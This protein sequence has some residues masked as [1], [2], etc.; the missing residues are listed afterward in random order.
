MEPGINNKMQYAYWNTIP[1]LC[2]VNRNLEFGAAYFINGYIRTM[3]VY[4]YVQNIV[5]GKI[6]STYT[7]ILLPLSSEL[8][9]PSSVYY[10]HHDFMK[11]SKLNADDNYNPTFLLVFII[12]S[13]WIKIKQN[14][15]KILDILRMRDV[16]ISKNFVIF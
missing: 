1:T 13:N 11:I 5:F 8:P 6:R 3:S 7:H 4:K 12:F 16:L 14:Q 10:Q 15:T 2:A 9:C